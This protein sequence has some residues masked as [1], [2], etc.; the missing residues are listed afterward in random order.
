MVH[1]AILELN[2][3]YVFCAI[4]QTIFN[5]LSL[6]GVRTAWDHRRRKYL[7]RHRQL[8]WCILR[9][10]GIIFAFAFQTNS[11]VLTTGSDPGIKFNL[12]AGATSYTIPGQL[13]KFGGPWCV[14]WLRSTTG[15]SVFSCSGGSPNPVTSISSTPIS[16]T[17]SVASSTTYSSSSPTST[18]T[19]NQYGQCGGI[20]CVVVIS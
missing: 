15:P 16:R 10:V 12:Y 4:D 7:S 17:T 3:M 6:D 13:S 18:G 5:L 2:F 1:R 19:V 20:G 8:P 9:W 11:F 14:Y